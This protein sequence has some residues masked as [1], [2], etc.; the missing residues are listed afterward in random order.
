MANHVVRAF[1]IFSITYVYDS[2]FHALHH[3]YSSN[4]HEEIKPF[5]KASPWSMFP[6]FLISIIGVSLMEVP[7]K[8]LET[9]V[10]NIILQSIAMFNPQCLKGTNIASF[11]NHVNNANVQAFPQPPYPKANIGHTSIKGTP[12]HHK[13]NVYHQP[14]NVTY[15][16]AA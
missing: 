14:I 13:K 11:S 3:V 7:S 10:K 6:V 8:V 5:P 9:Q 1:A 15:A 2:D 12:F 16:Q 4:S